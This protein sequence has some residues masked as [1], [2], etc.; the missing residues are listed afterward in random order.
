MTPLPY[1]IEPDGSV[2]YDS[3]HWYDS[4]IAP[5]DGYLVYVPITIP[6]RGEG[7]GKGRG[8]RVSF[9]RFVSAMMGALR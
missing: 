7:A 4:D 6:T 3:E 9:A 2:P 1:G 8:L 5:Y